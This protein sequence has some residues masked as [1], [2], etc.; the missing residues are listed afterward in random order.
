MQD[1]NLTRYYEHRFTF[2][3]LF[4]RIKRLRDY[5]VAQSAKVR[6]KSR[7]SYVISISK[8]HHLILPIRRVSV[9]SILSVMETL[10]L[11]PLTVASIAQRGP[12]DLI[13]SQDKGPHL[14]WDP[15]AIRLH[16]LGDYRSMS[17]IHV[18]TR[19]RSTPYIMLHRRECGIRLVECIAVMRRALRN[20][21]AV[22]RIWCCIVT[23]SFPRA[24]R[25]R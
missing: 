5:P 9:R 20:Y 1:I 3:R 12:R 17:Y 18:Q 19:P 4:S 22:C 8:T 15:R 14:P 23:T 16:F 13:G 25:H 11:F 7:P 6:V 24:G 21:W 2:A 10:L